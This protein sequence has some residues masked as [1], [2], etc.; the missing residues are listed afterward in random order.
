MIVLLI[1][2]LYQYD[3]IGRLQDIQIERLKKPDGKI[4]PPDIGQYI[5]LGP[6]GTAFIASKRP[7]VLLID[8]IDKSDIDLPNDLLNIFEEGS[9]E[10]PELSR[11]QQKQ[12]HVFVFP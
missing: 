10:I 4:E 11:I 5:R 6:L 12:E 1:Q 7:R 9:F 8:E 3:A 2:W